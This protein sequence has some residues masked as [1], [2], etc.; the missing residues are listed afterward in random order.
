[1]R[2]VEERF[3]VGRSVGYELVARSIRAGLLDRVSVLYGEPSLI[4]ATKEG[5]AF[6]ELGLP[7]ARISPGAVFHWIACADVALWAERQWGQEAVMGERELRLAEQ[8]ERKPIASAVVGELPGG[9]PRLHRPDLVVA[10]GD[11][12]TAIEVELTPKAPRRLE[13]IIRGWGRAAYVERAI[14]LCAPG[15][16][17]RGVESAVARAHAEDRVAVDEIGRVG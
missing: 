2:H 12:P 16:T 7:V 11:R 13:A 14:Y 10:T 8:L 5:I 4:R 1:V 3:G 6:A 15:A 17:R 9:R